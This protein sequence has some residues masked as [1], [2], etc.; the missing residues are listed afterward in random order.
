MRSSLY[1]GFA[2]SMQRRAD[3]VFTVAALNAGVPI[4]DERRQNADR[5]A[6][7]RR[8]MASALG[9][10]SARCADAGCAFQMGVEPTAWG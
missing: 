8:S 10:T 1:V 4:E 2:I 5:A 7:E 9:L 3:R 6:A